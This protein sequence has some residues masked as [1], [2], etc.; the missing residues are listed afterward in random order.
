MLSSRLTTTNNKPRPTS[1]VPIEKTPTPINAKNVTLTIEEPSLTTLLKPSP[2]DGDPEG[3]SSRFV[4]T[5]ERLGVVRGYAGFL[6]GVIEGTPYSG[7]F[8]EEAHDR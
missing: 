7:N 1:L 5:D 2:Q 6:S 4:G 8:E 3:M